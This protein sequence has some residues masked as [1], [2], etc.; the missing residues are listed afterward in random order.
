MPK[1]KITHFNHPFKETT[2]CS[3]MRK[4]R[5]YEHTSDPDDTTCNACRRTKIWKKAHEGKHSLIQK[6]IDGR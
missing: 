5:L 3:D 2:A 6:A 1:A 4:L